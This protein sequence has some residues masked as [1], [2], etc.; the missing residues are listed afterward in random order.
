M[1]DIIGSMDIRSIAELV[2]LVMITVVQFLTRTEV[3]KNQSDIATEVKRL[4]WREE[5][6][7]QRLAM[8]TRRT[9]PDK[10]PTGLPGWVDA[11]IYREIMEGKNDDTSSIS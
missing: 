2:L 5:K 6:Q 1:H 7:E 8:D 10:L 11:N 3:K 4:R 9:I